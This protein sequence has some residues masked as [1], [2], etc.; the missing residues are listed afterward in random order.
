MPLV[1]VTRRQGCSAAENQRVL[2]AV[3]EALVEA[4][5][6]P[7]GDR[8]QQLLEL[9]AA[10]FEIPAERGPRYALV[11][12]TAFPGRSV[13]AKRALYQAMARRCEAAG[14][15]PRD[16]FVVILEP[17]LEN[18]SPR[19]GVSSADHKPSFKLDV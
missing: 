15:P 13:E 19:D 9:D 12:I 17:P 4:F 6:I 8:H 18:W 16:L 11:E 1:K 3:H 5:K 7:A 2:D 14:V 10:H